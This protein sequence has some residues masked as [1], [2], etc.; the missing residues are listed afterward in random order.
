MVGEAATEGVDS[1]LLLS[2]SS[3]TRQRREMNTH[4]RALFCLNCMLSGTLLD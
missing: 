3:P 2:G 1:V 4:T